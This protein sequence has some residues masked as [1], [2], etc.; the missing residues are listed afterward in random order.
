MA[1]RAKTIAGTFGRFS[2]VWL[3]ASRCSGERLA[4]GFQ[5]EVFDQDVVPRSRPLFDI[6]R[7]APPALDRRAKLINDM[8]DAPAAAVVSLFIGIPSHLSLPL[9]DARLQTILRQQRAIG[10]ERFTF[11]A[12]NS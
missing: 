3:G 2:S 8:A 5:S 12:G 9:F 7:V 10:R 6:A 4:G 1:R 11:Q